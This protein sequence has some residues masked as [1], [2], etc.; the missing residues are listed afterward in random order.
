MSTPKE[1]VKKF[2]DLV[3]TSR[4]LLKELEELPSWNICRRVK[5]SLAYKKQIN[6]IKKL[7]PQYLYDTLLL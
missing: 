4:E 6:E 7:Y 2:V 5:L 1:R 3:N